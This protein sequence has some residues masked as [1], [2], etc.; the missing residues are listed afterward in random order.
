M[1]FFFSFIIGSQGS[2]AHL[3]EQMMVN[4]LKEYMDAFCII[5][6]KSF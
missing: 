2:I 3:D 6:F 5:W 4:N 1:Y